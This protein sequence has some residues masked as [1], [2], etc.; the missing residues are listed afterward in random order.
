[1]RLETISATAANSARMKNKEF[2]DFLIGRKDFFNRELNEE[3]FEDF[4]LGITR[5]LKFYISLRHFF[6]Q[7]YKLGKRGFRREKQL[8]SY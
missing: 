5:V 4:G 8:V 7:K 3:I 2:S 6:V 1:M